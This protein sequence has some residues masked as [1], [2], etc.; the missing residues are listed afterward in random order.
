MN[1]GS[2][3]PLSVLLADMPFGEYGAPS[4]ALGLLK[5]IGG[6]AGH[7]VETLPLSLHYA[8]RF[9]PPALYDSILE[10]SRLGLG[11][12]IFADAAFGD[13]TPQGSADPTYAGYLAR[14]GQPAELIETAAHLRFVAPGFLSYCLELVDWRRYDL[15]GFTTTCV[16][17]N[18]ALAL[19]RR[20]KEISPGTRIALGGA[21]CEGEMGA[22]LFRVFDWL[23][24]VFA[25]EADVAFPALLDDLAAG[26][27][28]PIPGVYRRDDREHPDDR[29]AGATA[30]P[31]PAQK[32]DLNQL[33]TPDYTDYFRW[34]ETLGAGHFARASVKLEG[35]RGC[36]WGE[37]SLCTFCGLN[38]S[39]VQFRSKRPEV[40]LREICEL[41]DH[42]RVF[43][44]GFTDNIIDHGYLD[45]LFP[46]LPELGLTLDIFVEIKSN[47]KRR[48]LEILR[49]AGVRTLQAGIEALD[50]HI[51][52]LMKKGVTGI[53]N[54]FLLRT[55]SELGMKVAWNLLFG[56]PGET[57]ADY[58]HTLD[59]L[60]SI[61]HLAPPEVCS[62]IGLDRFSPYYE[63]AQAP[64]EAN[65]GGPHIRL[66]GPDEHYRHV[67][68]LPEESLRRLAY[69]FAYR[70][71]G[72]DPATVPLF[73]TVEAF[74][75]RWQ[76]EAMPHTLIYYVGPSCLRIEDRR[77]NLPSRAVHFGRAE[78]AIYLGCTE[79]ATPEQ[80][81]RN[82]TA[83]GASFP[84]SAPEVQSFL[85]SLVTERF[86]L[87]EG[88]RYL[89][90][91]QRASGGRRA[92]DGDRPGPLSYRAL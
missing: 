53:Q 4:F 8:A 54:V 30:S 82:L 59:V 5:A 65:G 26:A 39:M 79:P 51:L 25:G 68:P 41:V 20:I 70:L 50:T 91:A 46:Q 15:V 56:F 27:G 22:E 89:A 90:L 92:G 87:R 33:P 80:L 43:R 35:S 7:R 37:K 11:E 45:T 75:S 60:Q 18:P 58:E 48:H 12:W 81:V 29:E 74:V 86:V 52:R 69:S 77:F 49:E 62:P 78:K 83:A 19:A 88:D 57:A 32:T 73:S 17:L 14:L 31:G 9:C 84:Y 47:L 38:G 13:F 63:A 44:L 72:R 85:D 40:V 10:K 16:E 36:W 42:H 34:F 21:K 28:R 6:R 24:F 3:S 55:A 2:T 23:D 1:G 76:S 67:L 66:T 71:E 61:T 64:P